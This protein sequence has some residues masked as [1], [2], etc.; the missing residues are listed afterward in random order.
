MRVQRLALRFGSVRIVSIVCVWLCCWTI[1]H[2]PQCTFFFKGL[3]NTFLGATS[4]RRQRR[5]RTQRTIDRGDAD[6]MEVKNS[7]G[8]SLPERFA[9]AC[10]KSWIPAYAGMTS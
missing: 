6:D 10:T 2:R 4:E 7:H 5:N 9:V 3:V 1:L 8:C